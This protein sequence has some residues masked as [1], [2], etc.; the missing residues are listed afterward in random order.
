[1]VARNGPP[2]PTQGCDMGS[3]HG[4]FYAN[5][6]GACGRY[7]Q[8]YSLKFKNETMEKVQVILVYGINLSATPLRVQVYECKTG[9]TPFEGTQAEKGD[10]ITTLLITRSEKTDPKSCL[11]SGYDL[12]AD[13]S[14]QVPKISGT[15]TV[16]SPTQDIFNIEYTTAE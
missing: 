6:P 4:C 1:M 12:G 10:L 13:F 3:E 2:E 16:C 14:H 5:S 8:A 7:A 15:Y 9:E 11:F